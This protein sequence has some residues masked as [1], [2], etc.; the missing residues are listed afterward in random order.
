[1]SVTEIIK[2]YNKTKTEKKIY[3]KTDNKIN[4]ISDIENLIIEEFGL[5]LRELKKKYTENKAIIDRL[6]KKLQFAEYNSNI[7]SDIDKCEIRTKSKTNR[8]K[9]IK[10]LIKEGAIK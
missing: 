10:S 8:L 5:T 1:M 4:A 3:I 6:K 2:N 9:K 7:L